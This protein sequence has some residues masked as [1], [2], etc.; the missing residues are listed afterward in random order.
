MLRGDGFRHREG[1]GEPLDESIFRD[2]SQTRGWLGDGL[3]LQRQAFEMK[4][5]G[6]A[7]IGAHLIQTMAGAGARNVG[8]KP[9]ML[10]GPLS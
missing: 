7:K 8:A 6:F 4:F 9:L 2:F 3:A 5:Q 10:L 1:D